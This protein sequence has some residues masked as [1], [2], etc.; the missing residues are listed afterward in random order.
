MKI[1]YLLFL[2]VLINGIAEAQFIRNTGISINNATL[3]T[4][5]G[6]WLNDAGTMITNNGTITTTDSF[7]NNGT[8]NTNS[9]GGFVFAYATDLSFVP[10]GNSFGFLRKEGASTLTLASSITLKD[11]LT[12]T[13][14]AIT[15]VNETDT[16]ALD[17][18]ALVTASSNAYVEGLMARSGTGDFLFPLGVDGAAL[19]LRLYHA[20][21][22]KITATIVEAP[23]LD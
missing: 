22:S 1:R 15:F 10:G 12:L 18:G 17:D 6:A 21:A 13:D 9:T 20:N 7:V 8:L 4:T 2:I 16:I 11:S 14:G 3:M 19:P 5:N 23:A